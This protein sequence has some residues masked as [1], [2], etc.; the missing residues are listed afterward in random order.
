MAFE[1]C[2][3]ITSLVADLSPRRSEFGS[4]SFHVRFVLESVALRNVPVF[5]RY[6]SASNIPPGLL[7]DSHSRRTL[8]S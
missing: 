5:L 3:W 7:P 2:I 8:T 1:T 6:S 4:G